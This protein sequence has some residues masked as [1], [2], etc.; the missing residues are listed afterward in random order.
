VKE[1]EEK[2]WRKLWLSEE[3]EESEEKVPSS[4]AR[5]EPQHEEEKMEGEEG[6][7]SEATQDKGGDTS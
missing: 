7:Q 4:S 5:E 2:K 6:V 1:P 3:M